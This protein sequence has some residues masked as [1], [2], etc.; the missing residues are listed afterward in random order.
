MKSSWSLITKLLILTWNHCSRR[1]ALNMTE[2]AGSMKVLTT[3]TSRHH[4][5]NPRKRR[6]PDLR[7]TCTGPPHISELWCFL[8]SDLWFS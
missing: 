2:I 5:F 3:G 8:F 6:Q 1:S 7:M 4:E